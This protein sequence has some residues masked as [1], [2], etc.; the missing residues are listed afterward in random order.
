[1]TYQQAITQN[2][3]RPGDHPRTAAGVRTIERSDAVRSGIN[4]DGHKHIVSRSHLRVTV[5]DDDTHSRIGDRPS[6]G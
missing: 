5:R 6:G 1:M 4:T 3:E 2:K